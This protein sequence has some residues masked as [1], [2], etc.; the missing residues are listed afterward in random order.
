MEEGFLVPATAR[1]YCAGHDFNRR[2]LAAAL[3][4]SLAA[5]NVSAA[6]I[7]HDAFNAAVYALIKCFL[8]INGRMVSAVIRIWSE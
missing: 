1:S 3:I 2:P 7:P 6:K 5:P 8:P 4:S